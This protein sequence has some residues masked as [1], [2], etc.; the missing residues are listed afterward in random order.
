MPAPA[1]RQPDPL[2]LRAEHDALAARLAARESID[3]VRAGALLGFVAV[4]AVGMSMKLA[5]DRWAPDA[6][7]PPG[8]S[9]PEPHPGAPAFFLAAAAVATVLVVAAVRRLRRARR[10]MREEAAL[11]DRLRALRAALGIDA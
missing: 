10:L 9:R 1:D 6:W 4:I 5:F 3:H 8:A 11:F 7:W 2:T